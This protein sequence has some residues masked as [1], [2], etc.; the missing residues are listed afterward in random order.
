MGRRKVIRIVSYEDI[1]LDT[2]FLVL[3][4]GE[5]GVYVGH[6]PVSWERIKV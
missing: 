5:T 4:F 6:N 2:I 3:K 1:V